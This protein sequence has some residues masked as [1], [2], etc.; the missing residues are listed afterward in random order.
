M[1]VAT[2]EKEALGLSV[3]ERGSL[4]SKLLESLGYDGDFIEVCEID[5]A[6][7]AELERRSNEWDENPDIGRP[8]DEVLNDI[9]QK[10]VV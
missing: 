5:P 6:L 9:R 10:F 4:A 2:L 1:D 7:L 3:K 8:A